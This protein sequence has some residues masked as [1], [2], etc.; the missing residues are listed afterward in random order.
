M[1]NESYLASL[2][3]LIDT[4]RSSIST[5]DANF[6]FSHAMQNPAVPLAH[7]KSNMQQKQMRTS[8]NQRNPRKTSSFRQSNPKIT[9]VAQSRHDNIQPRTLSRSTRCPRESA[10]HNPKLIPV[11]PIILPHAVSVVVEEIRIPLLRTLLLQNAQVP[12]ENALELVTVLATRVW[13]ALVVQNAVFVGQRS[14]CGVGDLLG[15][16]DVAVV[17]GHAAE[18]TE[19]AEDDALV[20]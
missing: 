7:P 3:S 15:C 12:R 2:A 1:T 6:L 17:V 16:C 18:F 5:V 11:I 10:P 14:D 20:V 13:L 9:S 8:R 19:A 4:S